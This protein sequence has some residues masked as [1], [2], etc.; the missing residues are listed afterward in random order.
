M[1]FFDTIRRAKDTST[2]TVAASGAL[3]PT[4]NKP[5]R[6][7]GTT[8]DTENDV[9]LSPGANDGELGDP[10]GRTGNNWPYPDTYQYYEVGQISGDRLQDFANTH[11]SE[12]PESVGRIPRQWDNR[13]QGK[14]GRD[15]TGNPSGDTSP[16]ITIA[17]SAAGGIGDM[18]YVPH[19]PTP[20]NMTVARPYLRTID[21][22]ANIPGVFVADATRR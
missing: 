22:S 21:D 8:P 3:T 17:G 12:N 7:S 4:A 2:K 5:I 1:G 15:I 18:Q 20:R 9:N 10:N 19:T 6:L 11:L 14:V 16:P 13:V